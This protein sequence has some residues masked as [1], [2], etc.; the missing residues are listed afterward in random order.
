VG[1]KEGLGD[2]FFRQEGRDLIANAEMVVGMTEVKNALVP[3]Q[4]VQAQ[5]EFDVGAFQHCE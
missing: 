1:L 3:T 4:E 5:Q 2:V